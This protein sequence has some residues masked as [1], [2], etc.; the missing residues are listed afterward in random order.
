MQ[1]LSTRQKNRVSEIFGNISVAWF[2][3]G[4]I[5]PVINHPKNIAVF[6]IQFVVSLIWSMIFFKFSLDFAKK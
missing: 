4:A 2:S 1:K 3:A 6:L 5:S